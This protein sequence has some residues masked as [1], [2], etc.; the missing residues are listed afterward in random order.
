VSL[1]ELQRDSLDDPADPVRT[2]IA[3]I[4]AGAGGLCMAA[5]LREHGIDDFVILEKSDGVG[6]TWRDNTYPDS[7]CDVPSHLYSFSFA[8]KPDWTRKWAKQPEILEY[9]ESIADRHGLRAHLRFGEEV[10]ACSW[11]DGEQCWD[12]RTTTGTTIRADVVVCA[13]G[14]LNMPNIPDIPG[15][16]DFRGTIFHSARWNHDHD[17][18]GERVGVIGIGASAIQFVPPVADEAAALTLFQRS[19]N[20]VYPKRDRRFRS[21][22]RRMLTAVPGLQRLYRWSIYWRLEARQGLMR[23]H[24][25]LG[26]LMQSTFRQSIR[27]SVGPRLPVEAL[28]PDYPPGCKRVLIADRWYPTLAEDHVEV[29]TSPVRRLTPEGAECADGTRYDL[30][31]LVFGTGFKTTD[32]LTPMA[33]TGRG[34]ADLNSVWSD[35]ASA[36]LGLSMSGFPNLFLLYGPN[37]NLGHNSILFMIEQQVDYVISVLAEMQRR[38]ATAAEVTTGAMF[39]WDREMRRRSARTVWA[40][41]CQSWYKTPDGRI[42]NNWVGRTTE[43]RR[44]L[45]RPRWTDWTFSGRS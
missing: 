45:R 22:E 39:R 26:R 18:R 16:E 19:P 42:T 28:V 36:Y 32:F 31:T 40:E 14:Q 3:I 17:L 37:T 15:I 23:R 9:F 35:G 2:A 12:L 24:S 20:Y 44:R 6:G 27:R 8:S 33:I 34:G 41:G 13:L 43:Y 11:L 7:A 38:G 29:V 25:L 1:D 10:T 5:R 21:W 4:G 30:D